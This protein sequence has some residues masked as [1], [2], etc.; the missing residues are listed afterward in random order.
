MSKSSFD[1]INQIDWL[2][3]GVVVV[4]FLV[5]VVK[6]DE[7]GIVVT[8]L[9]PLRAVTGKVPLLA[10]LETCVIPRVTGQPLSIGDISPCSTSS[11]P[12]PPIVW[13]AGSIEVH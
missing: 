8:A 6:I 7:V 12:A 10:A 5:I 11:S 3:R 2:L 9:L 4:V 1:I 13:G